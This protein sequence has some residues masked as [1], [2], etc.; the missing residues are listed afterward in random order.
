[1][2]YGKYRCYSISYAT[3][4][5]TL[6]KTGPNDARCVV[7]AVCKFFF[8]SFSCFVIT[9]HVY[10]FRKHQLPTTQAPAPP[11]SRRRVA[12]SPPCHTTTTPLNNEGRASELE[13][14]NGR[15]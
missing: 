5:A 4:R 10:R 7:W 11:P 1:M 14:T 15:D 8:I 13:T 9:N 12:T 2:F 6:T 3:G